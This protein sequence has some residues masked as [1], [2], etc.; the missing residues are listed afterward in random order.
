VLLALATLSAW[1]FGGADYFWEYVLAAVVALLA[2]LWAAHAVVT[3]RFRFQPDLVSVGLAGMVLVSVLQL[4]PL[5]LGVVRVL[6]PGRA[7]LHDALVPARPELLPGE[8]D[9][10]TVGAAFVPISL[11]P[12]ATRGFAARVLAVFVVYAAARNWLGGRAAFRRLAWAGLANGVALAAFALG[13]FFSSRGTV[14]F[15][16]VDVGV[17]PFGSFVCRNHYPDFVA[18]CLGLA[19]GLILSPTGKDPEKKK[20]PK[21]GDVPPEAFWDRVV[22]LITSPL[23]LLEKPAAVA[24]AL[25]AGLMLVSIPFSLSRGGLLA[26]IGA[27]AA[28]WV[29]GRWRTKAGDGVVGWALTVVVAVTAAVFLWQGT[30]PLQQRFSET[31][32]ARNADDRTAIWV[33]AGRQLP[34]FWLTGAGGGTFPRVEPLGRTDDPGNVVHDHAHNEYVEAA[35]EG[36]VVRLGL[37]LGLVGWLLVRVG[38]GYRKLRE[39]APGGLLLGAWFGL[40]MLALHA[41]TDFAVHV[42]AVSLL[43]AVVSGYAVAVSSDHERDVVRRKVRRRRRKA[44][45]PTAPA[46]G[47]DNHPTP[48]WG[49]EVAQPLPL[50]SPERTG[51]GGRS[52][53]PHSP[54]PV[55]LA[56]AVLLPVVCLL[57][58][59]DA[60]ARSRGDD[61]RVAADRVRRSDAADRFDKRVAYLERR[62]AVVPGD[63]AAWVDLAQA[64][65]DSAVTARGSADQFPPA[66][67][68][69]HIAPALRALRTA[70]DLCPAYPAVHARLGLYAAHFARSEPPRT[71]L[72]RAKRLLP[73]DAEVRYACG[74]EALRAGDPVAAEVDWQR[75]LE[76][77]PNNDPLLKA[78]LKAAAGLSPAALR[79]RVLPDDPWVMTAAADQL[80]PHRELQAAERRPFLLR[81]AAAVAL[82]T[83]TLLQMRGAAA[84]C[85]ELDRLDTATA[86]WKAAAKEPANA[87][88]AAFH[89]YAAQWFE[90]HELYEQALEHLRWLANR[91][92]QG[93]LMADRLRAAEHGAKLAKA[94][95]R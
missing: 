32:T 24:A 71:H 54:R 33:A 90:E 65:L 67:V 39:K 1:P 49:G 35:V 85:G 46:A 92:G 37:T 70:R 12:Y 56:F 50:P 51:D 93:R 84:A 18:L 14:M 81:A 95:R 13:Q 4:V 3:R 45:D 20:E 26:L 23:T 63:P 75:A 69:R 55:A 7:A 29:L 61:I 6:A 43:A 31:L 73:N 88:D 48:P 9:A 83:P 27:G 52:G 77:A 64:H 15:W 19:V 80:F 66:V 57:I 47:Q 34:G 62:A 59:L 11:D 41:A 40:L 36:G 89:A 16:T 38:A 78:I 53:R 79:E 21:P 8:P 87:N 30:D 86:M 2:G 5:P 72:E 28:A 58:T 82:P 42:P 74:V 10:A 25:A 60:R 94:L 91:P 17:R 76:L 44:E 68:E 22:D